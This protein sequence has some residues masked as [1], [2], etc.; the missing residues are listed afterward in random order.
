MCRVM[1]KP[2]REGGWISRW[3]SIKKK[4]GHAIGPLITLGVEAIDINDGF[5]N[6]VSSLHL[7]L[8]LKNIYPRL[9]M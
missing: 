6:R 4:I 3:F 5:D 9:R 7:L 2:N 8:L 1:Y